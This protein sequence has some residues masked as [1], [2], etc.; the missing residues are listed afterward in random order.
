[1]FSKFQFRNQ[2]NTSFLLFS[3][4]LLTKLFLTV[5]L[6]SVFQLEKKLEKIFS[7]KPKSEL[8]TVNEIFTTNHA[9]CI[10][11]VELG[12]VVFPAAVQPQ[13]AASKS[14]GTDQWKENIANILN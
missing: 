10:V 5:Y 8:M 1:M 13:P 12:N 14:A 11:E 2:L 6:L 3:F 9:F 4:C 7:N